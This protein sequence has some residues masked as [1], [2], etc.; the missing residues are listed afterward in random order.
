MSPPSY[1]K[2]FEALTAIVTYLAM[3]KWARRQPK[4]L[5]NESLMDPD[6]I[7]RVL[8][9]FKGLFRESTGR[10]KDYGEAYYSLHLRHARQEI[11]D[12]DR[13]RPPLEL[14]ELMAL[15]EFIARKAT[16]ERQRSTAMITIM[17]TAV[18]ALFASVTSL[19]VALIR[20]T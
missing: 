12:D 8:H 20:I 7:K 19:I 10:S 14:K 11:K 3:S 15:L 1:S 4:G 5:A 9:T 17:V 16:E 2:D 18:L 6:E 13:E